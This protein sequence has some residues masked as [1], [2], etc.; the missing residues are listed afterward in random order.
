MEL[1]GKGIFYDKKYQHLSS[2]LHDCQ[3]SSQQPQDNQRIVDA[4]LKPEGTMNFE[5]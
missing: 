3:L 1:K 5:A 4:E 2:I